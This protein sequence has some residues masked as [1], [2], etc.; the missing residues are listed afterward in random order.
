MTPELEFLK[1]W[2]TWVDAGARQDVFFS[3]RH[4]LCSLA[5]KFDRCNESTVEVSLQKWFKAE[6]LDIDY[7]FNDDSQDYIKE[8]R[9]LQDRKSVV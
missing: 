1:A 6:G 3:R 8:S 4:A 2:M 5:E 7:P 9:K